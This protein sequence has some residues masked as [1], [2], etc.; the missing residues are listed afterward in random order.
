MSEYKQEISFKTNR[1][2]EKII[3]NFPLFTRGFFSDNLSALS[4]MSYATELNQYF[5]YLQHKNPHF[6]NKKIIDFTPEDFDFIDY[7][8][9]DEYIRSLYGYATATRRHHRTTLLTFFNYLVIRKYIKLNPFVAAGKVRKEEHNIKY[10]DDK[11]KN[12]L[13]SGIESGNGLS[14]HQKKNHDRNLDRDLAICMIFL[15]TGLRISELVGLDLDDVDLANHCLT[16]T[17]KGYN[18]KE[19][20]VYLSDEAEGALRDYLDIRNRYDPDDNEY[21]VFLTQGRCTKNADGE[22]IKQPAE[23]ISVRAI[24]RMVKRYI[25]TSVPEKS[26]KITPHKLRTTFAMSMLEATDNDVLTVAAML[27]HK[28]LNTVQSYVE[29]TKQYRKDLRNKTEFKK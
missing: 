20:Q 24:E 6:K 19:D 2:V 5:T 10:L 7:M 1:K 16:V 25:N 21:A 26:G 3:E 13:L 14:V 17:R 22:K 28:G 9:A 8:A 23:R 27:N 12:N 18:E 11:E 29:S 4:K 15:S